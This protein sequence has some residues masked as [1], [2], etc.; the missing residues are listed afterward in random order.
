MEDCDESI[1]I[2]SNRNPENPENEYVR[3]KDLN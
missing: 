3:I 1:M 2:L